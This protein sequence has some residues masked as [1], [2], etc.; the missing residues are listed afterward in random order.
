[1]APRQRR[2]VWVAVAAVERTAVNG[3]EEYGVAAAEALG[4]AHHWPAGAAAAFAL[5]GPPLPPLLLCFPSLLGAISRKERSSTLMM[6]VSAWA[7]P[8]SMALS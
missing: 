2:S 8:D 7:K 4:A 3:A 6:L 5:G 1:M